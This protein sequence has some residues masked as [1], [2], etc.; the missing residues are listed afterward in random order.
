MIPS[1]ILLSS[2]NDDLSSNFDTTLQQIIGK[3]N[4]EYFDNQE[5]DFEGRES[6]C[7]ELEKEDFD[8]GE[9]AEEEFRSLKEMSWT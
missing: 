2:K 7:E 4:D 9:Y 5:W 6:S 3:Y 1:P 8:E